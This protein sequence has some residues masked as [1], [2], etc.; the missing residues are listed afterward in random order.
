MKIASFFLD[1]FNIL[2]FVLGVFLNVCASRYFSRQM[3]VERENKKRL[4][5]L[6]D[7]NRKLT[8]T[9]NGK[10]KL[11]KVNVIIQNYSKKTEKIT[12]KQSDL[13]HF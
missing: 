4:K 6:C 10:K 3:K 8:K 1:L 5:Q 7:K 12:F 9:C 11:K 2:A 13:F